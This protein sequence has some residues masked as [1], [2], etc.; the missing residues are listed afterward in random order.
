M[1][2]ITSAAYLVLRRY[3]IL[4]L[5]LFLLIFCGRVITR[6]HYISDVMA[7]GYIGFLAAYWTYYFMR[8]KITSCIKIPSI[9]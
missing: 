1:A 2:A 3:G 8:K 9:P 6:A 7:G 4:F 5:C